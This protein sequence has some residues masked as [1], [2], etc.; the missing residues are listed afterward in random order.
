MKFNLLIT[1]ITHSYAPNGNRIYDA[2]SVVAYFDDLS[3]AEVAYDV[4]KKNGDQ[5]AFE[6]TVEKLYVPTGPSV[7]LHNI[8]IDDVLFNVSDFIEKLPVT[9]NKEAHDHFRKMENMLH[10][11]LTGEKLYSDPEYN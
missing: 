5:G 11:L 10:E 8:E 4:M 9:I 1:T 2:T 7:P 3:S 6:I